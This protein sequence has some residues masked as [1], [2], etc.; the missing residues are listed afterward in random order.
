MNNITFTHDGI[1]YTTRSR[2][3]RETNISASTLQWLLDA[4]PDI[5]KIIEEHKHYY[6]KQQIKAMVEHFHQNRKQK[7]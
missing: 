3:I 2:I 6:H 7:K 4:H 5:P 1:E